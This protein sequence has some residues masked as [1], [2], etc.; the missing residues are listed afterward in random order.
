MQWF[1][2]IWTLY[3][4]LFYGLALLIG[5][6][7]ALTGSWWMCLPAALLG[8]PLVGLCTTRDWVHYGRLLLGIPI[9]LTGWFMVIAHYDYPQLH[10]KGNYGNAHFE[11]N[12][13]STSNHHFGKSWLYKGTLKTFNTDDGSIIG[14]NIPVT[15][16]IPFKAEITHPSASSSFIVHGRLKQTKRGNYAFIV[17]PDSPWYPVN[18]S[19]SLAEMRYK[20]KQG[21]KSY[22]YAHIHALRSAKFL[23]GLATGEFDDRMMAFEFSRFGLQHLMA[24]S[25]F[26]FG[27][28]AYFLSLLVRCL[29]PRRMAPWVLI[30]GLTAY[31]IFLGVTASV[32]RSWIGAMVFFCGQLV[33][34][35]STGLNALGVGLLAILT[36]DPLACCQLG[37]QF[38][39]ATTAAILIFHSPALHLLETIWPKR[40]LSEMIAMNLWNQHAYLILNFFKQGL[41][42]TLAVS[43]IAMPITIYYFHKFPWLSLIY[44]L[45]FPFMVS[46][47]M[48]LL[49]LGILVAWVPPL[50]TLIHG[51]NTAYTEFVLD[52]TYNIPTQYDIILYFNSIP[53]EAILAYVSFVFF[54]GL[55]LRQRYR[56]RTD[57]NI[58]LP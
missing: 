7:T 50:S 54:C 37:F 41:A 35:E 3:P 10:P 12:S 39:F 44:N 53:E 56:E 38:S 33:E 26:H 16:S 28:I 14:H 19:W 25:G 23:T 46:I 15:V 2:Q 34:R 51:I 17:H 22:I 30:V 20:A 4:A 48:F 36:L 29:L 9:A 8:F 6:G 1:A 24:I 40:T 18:N 45:F 42:L 43:I 21:V 31:F 57:W 52:F 13:L 11:I 5:T 58:P 47:A 27:I 55:V 32:M 49:M